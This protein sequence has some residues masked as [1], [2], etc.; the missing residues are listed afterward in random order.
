MA[1]LEL[2][3]LKKQLQELLDKGYIRPSV[4][5]WGAPVLF[6]RKKDGT[7]RLCIDYRKL[8]QV[9]VKN[10]Y[11]LPRVDDLFDQLQGAQVFSKIDLRSSY[12]QLKIAEDDVPKTAFRTRYGHYKFLVMPFGLTNALAAFMAL[13]N[14]VFQPY[15]DRFVIVFIDDIL[16]YSQSAEEHTEHLRTVLQTLQNRKLYAKFSKCEFWLDHVAFLGHVISAR[17]IEVDP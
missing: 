10:K 5:P 9:T 7:L 3:E 12:H 14:R 13:M 11:P 17:G 6:V 2:Q 16:V 4:S 15:L 8:N 1:P